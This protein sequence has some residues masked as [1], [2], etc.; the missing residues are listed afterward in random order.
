MLEIHQLW[1]VVLAPIKQTVWKLL[2]IVDPPNVMRHSYSAP[3]SYFLESFF[4][5]WLL[6]NQTS[7]LDSYICLI[8][9]W[10]AIGF[11]FEARLV[12][13]DLELGAGN[14]LSLRGVP[15]FIQ[16]WMK[17][18]LCCTHH[19]FKCIPAC[20]SSPSTTSPWRRTTSLALLHAFKFMNREI[21]VGE[22]INDG[23][24]DDNCLVLTTPWHFRNLKATWPRLE[25]VLTGYIFLPRDHRSIRDY[26]LEDEIF[27]CWISIL[28]FYTLDDL[29]LM[30]TSLALLHAFK[31]MN[32]Q[33]NPDS[34]LGNRS[35]F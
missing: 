18:H 4:L 2:D 11:K 8:F 3:L 26:L 23:D 6:R 21:R 7:L 29:P 34:G 30:T 27:L 22:Q 15:S 19:S 31:F 12:P 17:D 25:Q 14:S 5:T 28:L 1:W 16:Q 20:C 33:I 13:R 24:D 9:L 10:Q 32:R 35:S